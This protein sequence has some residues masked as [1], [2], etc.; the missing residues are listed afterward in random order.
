MS[1]QREK[2]DGST[3]C[4]NA[5]TAGETPAVPV[6]SSA[7]ESELFDSVPL[8]FDFDK[9]MDNVPAKTLF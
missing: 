5:A 8:Y 3:L 1:A 9:A 4:A 2:F 6:K 7:G